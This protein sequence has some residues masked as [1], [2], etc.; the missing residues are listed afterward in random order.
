MATFAAR[1]RWLVVGAW[2]VGLLVLG[3]LVRQFG[4]AYVDNFTLPGAPSQQAQYALQHRFPAQA[5]DTANLVAYAPGGI[6]SAGTEAALQQVLAQTA[7]LPGV[8]SVS[9]PLTS[10]DGRYAYVVLQY[11]GQAS[12]IPDSSVQA[13]ESLADRS[14]TDGLEV[15]VGGSVVSAHEGS[16]HDPY[17]TIGL[18]AAVLILLL[19]FGSF[20]AMG[21]PLLSALAGLGSGLLVVGVAARFTDFSTITPSFVAMIGLGIGIDYALFLITRHRQGLTAG[22]SVEEAVVRAAETSGRAVLTAGSLVVIALLG[23]YVIGIPFIGNLGAAA[24]A[25]VAVNVLVALTLLP[26]ILSL[27]GRNLD[28]WRIQRLYH[29]GSARDAQ[30]GFGHRLSEQI[31]RRPWLYAVLGTA[32]PLL[33]ALP[34]LQMQLGFS[35]DGTKPESFHSRRAYDLTVEGF[36]PGFVS[37]LV[38]VVEG[39]GKLDPASLQRLQSDIQGTPGVALAAPAA[40][41]PDGTAAVLRVVPTTG[42]SD[43]ATAGLVHRLRDSVIPSA[44]Q[45]TGLQ[46]EVGGAT[47]ALVDIVGQTQARMPLFFAIVIGL[48]SLLLMTIFRSLAIP[49]TAAVMNLLSVGASYGAVVA[50]FQWGWGARLIGLDTTGPVEAYL[51]IILFAILFGLSTDYEVFLLSQVRER[52]RAGRPT[53]AAVAEGLAATMRVIGAAAA[54]MATV[55]L[56]FLANN[57]RPIKEFGLG[58]A[59]AVLVDAIVIRLLLVPAAMQLLGEWNW[60]MPRWLDRV[61]PQFELDG[62]PAPAPAPAPAGP[63]DR[64]PDASRPAPR[65]SG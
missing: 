55:F 54:I 7:R 46:A 31:Q 45:G 28:R 36:G 29:D 34:V 12:A 10:R 26:A 13:L 63:H 25:V 51:P 59:V 4:G 20:L 64:S 3:L 43:P 16:S 18:L 30:R 52:H 9:P 49:A 14:T 62:E 22:M 40:S 11:D 8:S 42:S 5:G 37:P 2:V 60:W 57:S 24:A 50:V 17:E 38:V 23:L 39:S 27:I 47:A 65:S 61:L 44:V 48:S 15:Q 53:H 35:D 6:S 58:L 33:M 19:V 21:L 32:V 1:R 41:N 56:A